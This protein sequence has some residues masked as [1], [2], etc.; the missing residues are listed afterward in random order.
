M[1]TKTKNNLTI[2]IFL[3]INILLYWYAFSHP[4]SN[5]KQDIKNYVETK[6]KIASIDQK[7]NNFHSFEKSY[8]A[9]QENL[10]KME[11]LI[12]NNLFI[13]KEVPVTFTQSLEKWASDLGIE[14]E[15]V[16][17]KIQKTE[18][19]FRDF[20]GYK[21]S[22]QSKRATPLLQFLKKL[23]TSQWIINISSVSLSLEE[24]KDKGT[25]IVEDIFIK[26][27]VR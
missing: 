15:I 18:T 13:D 19:D 24:T 20:V 7:I 6:A 1:N 12:N 22:L 5:V 9:Y 3:I 14:I 21:V 4:F 27:Y 26:V 25:Y 2:V 10:K 17:T 16:P 8:G 23:E 11:D